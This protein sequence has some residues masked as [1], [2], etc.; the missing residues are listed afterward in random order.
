MRL[1]AD[2]DRAAAALP[3]SVPHTP[4]DMVVRPRDCN[5]SAPNSSVSVFSL[6]ADARGP[7]DPQCPGGLSRT[8]HT[9]VAVLLGVILV[10]GIFS[11]SLVLLVFV[12]YRSLWTPINLIL[13]NISLSDILV[14]VFGTS[15]S[16]AASLQG[17]WLIGEGGC[18][19]Y[20]F[21]N[22]LFGE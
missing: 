9:A 2:S 12:K 6:S 14:C 16:F 5:V 4:P 1:A 15:F 17:R 20:G 3:P 22:S 18:M 8:S 13:L 10:A 19:W 7:W 11:N 21:A